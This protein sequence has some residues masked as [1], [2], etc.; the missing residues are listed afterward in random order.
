[1]LQLIVTYH[2]NVIM[3]YQIPDGGCWR[4]DPATRCLIVGHGLPRTYVPL[5]TVRSF[6]IV[7]KAS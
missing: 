1:M 7:G 2:D 4:I 3:Y 5:D 6:E